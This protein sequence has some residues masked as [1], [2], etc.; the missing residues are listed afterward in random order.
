MKNWR[1]RDI[2]TIGVRAR[3]GGA[4]GA[5]APPVSEIGEILQAK[6]SWFGQQHLGE[7]KNAKKRKTK[8]QMSQ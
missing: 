5:A 6:R 1:L 4:R 8:R 2:E 7:N 3:G